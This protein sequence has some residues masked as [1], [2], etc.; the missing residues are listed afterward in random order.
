MGGE[1]PVG[2]QRRGLGVKP[3]EAELGVGVADIEC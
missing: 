3:E 1:S 2:G